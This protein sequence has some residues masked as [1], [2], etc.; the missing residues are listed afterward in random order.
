MDIQTIS[1]KFSF[2][3]KTNK[4]E[5][6]KI[7]INL[8]NTDKQTSVSRSASEILSATKNYESYYFALSKNADKTLSN[9]E[10]LSQS[11]IGELASVGNA[12]VSKAFKIIA[13]VRSQVG[14]YNA[15][16]ANILANQS[17]SD[18]EKNKKIKLLKEKIQK[19]FKEAVLKSEKLIM[20]TSSLK[21]YALI[22][23][24][25]KLNNVDIDCIIQ[26]LAE[27]ANNINTTPTNLSNCESANDMNDEIKKNKKSFFDVNNEGVGI[28]N[29][30]A[31]EEK[32]QFLNQKIDDPKISPKEKNTLEQELILYNSIKNMLECLA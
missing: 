2:A 3:K 7:N 14:I 18:S 6:K 11:N 4:A 30:K 5:V 25:L 19:I 28:E 27:M 32:I 22:L 13:N 1:G 15:E 29:L 12:V 23:N 20:F 10:V 24:K 26:I 21:S 17:L 8:I 31:V 16:I 9:V